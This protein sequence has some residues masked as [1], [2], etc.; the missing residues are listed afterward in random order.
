MI[1]FQAGVEALTIISL[2]NQKESAVCSSNSLCLKVLFQVEATVLELSVLRLIMATVSAGKNAVIVP[3]FTM[4]KSIKSNFVDR[5]SSSSFAL[6]TY[7]KFFSKNQLPKMSDLYPYFPFSFPPNHKSIHRSIDDQQQ[8]DDLSDIKGDIDKVKER[9]NDLEN[10]NF[11]DKKR[12][13]Q[14][15]GKKVLG[16]KTSIKMKTKPKKKDKNETKVKKEKKYCMTTGRFYYEF[17]AFKIDENVLKRSMHEQQTLARL[18]EIY[19]DNNLELVEKDGFSCNIHEM[20]HV[21]SFNL[22]EG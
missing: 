22:K 13:K 7:P 11:G 21:C 17:P 9:P 2:F 20:N 3:P 4:S 10:S 18:R 15:Q 19:G 8:P 14:T 5:F 6:L 16:L 1:S 12:K